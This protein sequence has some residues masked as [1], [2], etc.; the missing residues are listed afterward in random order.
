MPTRL[1]MVVH[2]RHDHSLRVPR[3][4]LSARFGTPNAC[5][6]CH[7]EHAPK[8]AEETIARWRDKSVAPR[9]HFA[10]ALEAGR[11]GSADSEQRLAALADDTSQPPIARATAVRELVSWLTSRSLPSVERAARDSEPLLRLAAAEITQALPPERG[12]AIAAPLLRDPLRAVRATAARA[13]ATVPPSVLTASNQLPL[14]DALAEWRASQLANDDRPEAHVSLGALHAQKGEAQAARQEYET[15][16][17]VGPWFV[18]AYLDLADLERSEGRDSA[19]GEWLEKA[20]ALAPTNADVHL[21]IGLLRVREGRL[22]DA[23]RELKRAAQLAPEDAHI[24]VVYAMALQAKGQASEALAVLDAMHRRRPGEREPLF[25]LAT[26]ARE[27]GQPERARQAAH[28][29]LALVPDDPDAVALAGEVDAAEGKG[30]R[31]R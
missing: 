26:I 11:R 13:L 12:V 3:P 24:T 14:T 2:A 15:A 25:A 23:E 27:A 9:V 22:Q 10:E 1:Y 17:R 7:A 29:L 5:E 18:P 30:A 6:G 19:A 31:S 21:A 28:D 4:D 20:L 16:L 8:W